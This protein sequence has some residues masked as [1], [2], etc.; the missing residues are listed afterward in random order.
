[1]KSITT[2]KILPRPP[3]VVVMGHIDHGKS[4]LL[5]YIR[6]TNVVEGESG[7]ITQHISAYEVLHKTKEGKEMKITFL[8]TPGHAAFSA[9]RAHGAT[10][11]DIAILVVSAEDGVKAQ[12]LEAAKAIK[13]ASI[14]FV[15]AINKIDKPNADSEKVKRELSEKEVYLEGYGGDVPY[16]EISAKTGAG[17]PDLLDLILLVSELANLTGDSSLP[18]EGFVIESHRDPKRGVSATLV[19]TNGTLTKGSFICAGDAITPVR[20]IEDSFGKSVDEATFSAPVLVAGFDTLP[21]SGSLFQSFTGKRDAE[22]AALE[23]KNRTQKEQEN[24]IGN[25]EAEVSLPLILKTDVLGS[26]DAVRQELSKIESPK[27]NIRIIHAGVGDISENDVK[28]AAGSEHARIVG[29]RVGVDKKAHEGAERSGISIETFTIIYNI[30]DYVQAEILK[31]VPKEEVEE[32]RGEARILRV[33][34]AA[35]EK[36]VVG[37]SM[38][39]GSLGTGNHIKILRRSVEVGRGKILELQQQKI[40]T[41]EIKDGEFGMMAESRMEIAPGDVVAGFVIVTK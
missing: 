23:E 29:F 14:P 26:Q 19:I 11:A 31:R 7:G 6:K 8:D 33:F 5:D 38:I 13:E 32:T 34:S 3:V 40:K 17:I 37:G 16:A 22:G 20:A 30:T 35:R 10:A 25:P 2:Q 39:S 9:M 18:A 12:T 28:A 41:S 1:M 36:Q 27:V 15:V 21:A 4:T 24:I